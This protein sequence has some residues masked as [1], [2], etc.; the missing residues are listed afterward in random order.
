MSRMISLSPVTSATT[1]ATRYLLFG[2]MNPGGRYRCMNACHTPGT[3][4]NGMHEQI[5]QTAHP[6][7][8]AVRLH[9]KASPSLSLHTSRGSNLSKSD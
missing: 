4:A 2:G 8:S 7:S 5:I 9:R 1:L 3:S 6:T